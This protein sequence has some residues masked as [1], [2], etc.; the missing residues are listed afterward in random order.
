MHGWREDLLGVPKD[1][2]C[3][4]SWSWNQNVSR[5]VVDV[6]RRRCRS[7]GVGETDVGCSGGPYG[8]TSVR[9][10]PKSKKRRNDRG[11][12]VPSPVCGGGDSRDVNLQKT[13]V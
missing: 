11:L 5:R 2:R 12:Q 4:L 13:R 6:S 3:F 9:S 10:C 8:V 7:R 1:S